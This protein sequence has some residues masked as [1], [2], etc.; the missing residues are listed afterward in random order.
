LF[1]ICS[2]LAL[3]LIRMLIL[4]V[5]PGLQKTG[6]GVVRAQ[7]SS[8]S[9]VASGVLKT[10]PADPLCMRLAHLHREMT[11]IILL[12]HPQQAA[13]EE[14]FVNGNPASAL[15]LGQARGALLAALALQGLD[16]QEY[17]PNR[18]K[19]SIVGAGHAGK[20]QI[21]LMVKRL[22]PACGALSEDE[23]DALAVAIT[24]AHYGQGVMMAAS[25]M[26]KGYTGKTQTG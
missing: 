11:R 24:Q 10:Q 1:L 9:H 15:K 22:L 26:V 19:K 3:I 18:I 4:G 21:G 13:I 23:A 12:Y 25:A 5:D 17:A 8:L 2:D 14:T 6:W 7:G 16:V 20:E